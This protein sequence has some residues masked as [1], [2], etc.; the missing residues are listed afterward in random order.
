MHRRNQFDLEWPPHSG[1]RKSFPEVDQAAFFTL[2][3]A[4]EKINPAQRAFL[5]ELQ[6][7]FGDH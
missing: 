4:R 2:E 3:A 6:Q 7:R 5:E 1:R